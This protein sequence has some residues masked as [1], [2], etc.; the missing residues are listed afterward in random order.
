[1]NRQTKSKHE[2]YFE[3]QVHKLG[4]FVV[5][6]EETHRC[7]RRHDSLN[8]ITV[9]KYIIKILTNLAQPEMTLRS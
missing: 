8:K 4:F 1:M 2:M 3:S 5:A 6:V 9:D 7:K